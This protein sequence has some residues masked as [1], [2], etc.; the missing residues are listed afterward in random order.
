MQ[1]AF[2]AAHLH[3]PDHEVGDEQRHEVRSR[4]RDERGVE[5]CG[6]GGDALGVLAVPLTGVA[7]EVHDATLTQEREAADE[8]RDAELFGAEDAALVGPPDR[9]DQVHPPALVTYQG[10]EGVEQLGGIVVPG[11]GDHRPV[12]C[13]PQEP[14]QP[15]CQRVDRGDGTVED[16]AGDEHQIRLM[17]GRDPS[18]LLECGRRLGGTIVPAETA[19][20]VPVG[21]MQDPHQLGGRRGGGRTAP[22]CGAL[23]TSARRTDRHRRPP[24]P[25]SWSPTA[26]RGT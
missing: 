5:G 6:Q 9:P 14:P 11:D 23:L 25:P 7:H 24:P 2:G 15:E 3:A 21:G 17:L 16:V 1:L 22:R 10:R 8:G 20:D 4:S 26:G 19:A 12:F 13:Q 18:D